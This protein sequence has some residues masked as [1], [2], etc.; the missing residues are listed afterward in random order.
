MLRQTKNL[1]KAK[2]DTLTLMADCSRNAVLQV[3]AVKQL[4][5]ELVADPALR[6]SYAQKAAATGRANHDMQTTA[7]RVR[8]EMEGLL[9][10]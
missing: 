7:A 8:R 5:R 9:H 1:Q 6:Q 3:K 2:F 10:G 4:L